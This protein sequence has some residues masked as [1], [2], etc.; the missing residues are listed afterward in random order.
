MLGL[1]ASGP[2]SMP[3]RARL[4]PRPPNTRLLPA[5]PPP[6]T[7]PPTPLPALPR[8]YYAL[9]AERFSKVKREYA[10]CFSEAFVRQYQLI[11]R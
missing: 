10:D 7:H 1:L 6:T 9:M 8:R 3:A 11:H 4:W 5:T 2:P